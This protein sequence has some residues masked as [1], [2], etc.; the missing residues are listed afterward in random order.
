MVIVIVLWFR[1]QGR[2]GGAERTVNMHGLVVGWVGWGHGCGWVG[3]WPEF[4]GRD[5][6][7]TGRINV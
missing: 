1:G 4:G 3:T 5:V 2:V 6:N 7:Y